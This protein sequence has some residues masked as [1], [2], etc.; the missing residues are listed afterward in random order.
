M[1]NLQ[2]A[3]INTINISE[4][5]FKAQADLSLTNQTVSELGRQ[6][7]QATG[8]F[9]GAGYALLMISAVTYINSFI[10]PAIQNPSWLIN[11]MGIW[12]QNMAFPLL[13]FTFVFYGGNEWRLK[14]EK[15]L[16]K[17]FSYLSLLM[18]VLFFALLPLG[19]TST[20]RLYNEGKAQLSRGLELNMMALQEAETKVSTANSNDEITN[21]LRQYQ[22]PQTAGLPQL[23]GDTRRIKRDLL[24]QLDKSKAQLETNARVQGQQQQFVLIRTYVQQ[25]LLAIVAVGIFVRLWWITRWARVG[26]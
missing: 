6:R 7:R 15:T 18:A 12:V 22:S 4:Q 23:T 8:L 17:I 19:L 5:L 25:G 3:S 9:R 13:G 2:E 14:R 1:E 21:I 11:L 10:P 24:V 16:V 20:V 26:G